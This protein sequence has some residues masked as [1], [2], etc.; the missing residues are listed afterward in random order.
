MHDKGVSRRESHVN[1]R[2]GEQSANEIGKEKR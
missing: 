2:E 1:V